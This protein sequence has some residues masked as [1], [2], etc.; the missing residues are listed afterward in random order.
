MMLWTALQLALA[1]VACVAADSQYEQVHFG[2]PAAL[3]GVTSD[4]QWLVEARNILSRSV[5]S[6]HRL[7]AGARLPS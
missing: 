2:A 6:T 4:A 7:E 5:V 3:S 1:A